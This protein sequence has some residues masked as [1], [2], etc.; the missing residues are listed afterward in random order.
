VPAAAASEEAIAAFA[1]TV[2]ASE[3][4]LALLGSARATLAD[5]SV[6][7]WLGALPRAW[8][9]QAGSALVV[10]KESSA[11]DDRA[12][13]VG[14]LRR[15]KELLL[16]VEGSAGL[17]IEGGLRERILEVARG[18]SACLPDWPEPGRDLGAV[19]RSREQRIARELGVSLD[20]LTGEQRAR[21]E[22]WGLRALTAMGPE[23]LAQR[24][25]TPLSRARALS[26]LALDYQLERQAQPPD[27]GNRT[28][29]ELAWAELARCAR[30][31]DACDGEQ[32]RE[33]QLARRKRREAVTLLR[34]LLAERG[35]LP[36]L[37][38]LTPCATSELLVRLR[39]WLD[40]IASSRP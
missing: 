1:A 18:F 10:L 17:L 39:I 29:L 40:S 35:E 26:L 22:Q 16:A 24:L 34:L 19:A 11:S 14:A 25:S 4:A 13:L 8:T 6:K 2:A 20:G 9:E 31:F 36:L 28:A 3:E 27:V 38:A 33:E 21:L 23:E 15:L 12:A 7:L 37:D 32:G 30:A 5:F